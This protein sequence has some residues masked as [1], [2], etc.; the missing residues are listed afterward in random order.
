MIRHSSERKIDLIEERLSGIEDALRTIAN[1]GLASEFNHLRRATTTTPSVPA[2]AP[3]GD[4]QAFAH[5]EPDDDDDE[6]EAFEGDL[7]LT[8]HTVFARDFLENAVQ[9]T[10]LSDV[11]PN[12]QS[13]LLTL[14]QMVSMQNESSSIRELKFPNQQPL[15]PGGLPELPMPP[16]AAVVSLLKHQKGLSAPSLH[17]LRTLRGPQSRKEDPMLKRHAS[18]PAQHLRHSLLLP[19]H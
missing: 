17:T 3:K 14:R 9:R 4:A 1:S 15:P 11:T 13:A 2:S 19:R 18:G 16:M 8:A 7:S 5:E 6:T 10:S 12:M